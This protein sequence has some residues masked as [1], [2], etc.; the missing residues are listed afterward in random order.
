MLTIELSSEEEEEE[1]EEKSS[2]ENDIGEHAPND[3]ISRDAEKSPHNDNDQLF[4]D[5]QDKL[6]ELN[7]RETKV[8]G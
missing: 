2:T 8:V 1:E 5:D 7:D 3:N 6:A 4:P